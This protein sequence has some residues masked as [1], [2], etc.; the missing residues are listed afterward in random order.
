[1]LIV[2]RCVWC[3]CFLLFVLGCGLFLVSCFLVGVFFCLLVVWW[4][5]CGLMLFACL[6][7]FCCLLYVC[8]FLF[9]ALGSLVVV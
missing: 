5:V 7:G 4:F 1:M 8:F 2:V 6:F 3:A 9:V